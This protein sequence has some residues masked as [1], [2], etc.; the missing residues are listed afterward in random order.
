MRHDDR[1]CI[2]SDAPHIDCFDISTDTTHTT[3]T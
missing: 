1:T 3:L 2:Q